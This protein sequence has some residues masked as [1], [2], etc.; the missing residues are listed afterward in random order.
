MK[1]QFNTDNAAFEE[2]GTQYQVEV[3][4]ERIIQRIKNGDTEGKIQD[5]NGNNI[6]SWVL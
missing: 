6:G 3:I 5:I 2:Y 1:I 4:F